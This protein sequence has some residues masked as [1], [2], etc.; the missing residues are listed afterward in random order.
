[1]K[2][3]KE[4]Q[5]ILTAIHCINYVNTPRDPD[6]WKLTDYAFRRFLGA[7]TNILTLCCVGK[8]K[9]QLMPD[10]MELLTADTEYQ[11]YLDEY[12]EGK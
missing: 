2:N 9:E 8:T 4:L 10:I 12:K 3:T 7:N 1:M 11:K 6:I 5:P